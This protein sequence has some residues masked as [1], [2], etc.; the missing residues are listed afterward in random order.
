M[1]RLPQDTATE[2][3]SCP[4]EIDLDVWVQLPPD[5]R[6][7]L[8]ANQSHQ[9]AGLN[10][11]NQGRGKAHDL[12]KNSTGEIKGIIPSMFKR[13]KSLSDPISYLTDIQFPADASSI[14]GR[15]SSAS[16]QSVLKCK[17]G[18]AARVRQV[19]KAG[20]N[21][22][23]H[24]YACG[25]VLGAGSKPA[26]NFFAWAQNAPHSA[27][28]QGIQWKRFTADDGWSFVVSSRGFRAE[29]VLQGGVGNC[30]FL[31]AVAV[32]AER[33]DLIEKVIQCRSFSE[34]GSSHFRFF[35]DGH[36]KEVTV[37]N[38]LPYHQ[39]QKVSGADKSNTELYFSKAKFS[40]LWVPFLEK[41]YAKVHGSYEA[42]SGGFI[43]EAML[44]L[45][46]APC[47]TICFFGDAFNSEDTW[48][49]LL[50]F[51]N[52]KFPMGCSTDSTG[53]GIVGNHAYSILDVQQLS[54]AKLGSQSKI[55][56]F[57]G[58][59]GKFAQE[60]ATNTN[61]L[62]GW[63]W[64]ALTSLLPP[65]LISEY[66]QGLETCYQSGVGSSGNDDSA[67]QALRLV[68]IRNPWGKQEW[69]GEMS[70]SS[71]LWTTKL[72][73]EVQTGAKND[74]TFWMF[75]H[76]FLRRFSSID[77]CK[78]FEDSAG[79][80]RSIMPCSTSPV[81]FT[82]SQFQMNIAAYTWM[83]LFTTQ[84]TKR[85]WMR[86]DIDKNY[87]YSDISLMVT[88]SQECGAEEVVGATFCGQRR[89]C[90]PLEL[91][92]EKGL[93]KIY[94]VHFSP[95]KRSG[96]ARTSMP[97][98]NFSLISYCS[99]AD[100]HLSVW[101]ETDDADSFDAMSARQFKACILHSICS[102]ARSEM[103]L[104]SRSTYLKYSR[105]ASMT[106]C[107]ERANSACGKTI[108]SL[109]TDR[110]DEPKIHV[111]HG[112][113]DI[114]FILLVNVGTTAISSCVNAV[115][116]AKSQTASPYLSESHPFCTEE[117]SLAGGTGLKLLKFSLSC[118][119][120]SIVC[121]AVIFENSYT[122]EGGQFIDIRVM[123]DC[124][125]TRDRKFPAAPSNVATQF[126]PFSVCA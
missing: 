91:H 29:D 8:Q 101:S 14:D 95:H 17:C 59:N 111:L 69:T 118:P 26:C 33:A 35:I 6:A 109:D 32:I 15:R 112:A 65:E 18:K 85:G 24:F 37:D 64:D 39:K 117:S 47:Q 79:W 36:W 84:K 4:E 46:C 41:S 103:D 123:P 28:V 11:S 13:H 86:S 97:N 126:L 81:A 96:E 113:C 108:I 67:A 116:S 114:A 7:E 34:N 54:E 49:M 42:I 2:D 120:L 102:E 58:K 115:V 71:E 60:M 63:D 72:L 73:N 105:K 27:K 9:A 61:A 45:T 66:L 124:G 5:I 88:R 98:D 125:Y 40:Q 16:L 12:T 99:R 62:A 76:D 56:S 52:A 82:A 51:N 122:V 90:V 68:R 107:V 93:Y 70:K 77:I 44:D 38:F 1:K 43:N 3:M 10:H 89:D 48:E 106:S 74:G 80:S 119:A 100:A 83:Y 50:S 57:F 55:H 19:S 75:Y 23:R 78:C 21:Q 53:E 25:S 104:F 121:I 92:L 30:W 31:S 20:V 87:W 94:V 110:I 22:G